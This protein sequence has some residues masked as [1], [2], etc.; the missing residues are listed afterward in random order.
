MKIIRNF[1]LISAVGV[2]PLTISAQEA[3]SA[4]TTNA[5]PRFQQRLGNVVARPVVGKLLAV[6][7]AA[8]TLTIGP[9]EGAEASQAAKTVLQAGTNT[10]YYRSGRRATFDDAVVGDPIRYYSRKTA[11][12]KEIA[13][14]VLFGPAP[15]VSQPKT[16]DNTK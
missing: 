13:V 4:A 2:L 9:S 12:G 16:P 11:D 15:A 7:K 14:W 3:K 8:K 1:L 6:D 5:N 10:M